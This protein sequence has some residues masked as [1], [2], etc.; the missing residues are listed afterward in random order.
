MCLTVWDTH[1]RWFTPSGSTSVWDAPNTPSYIYRFLLLA[2]LYVPTDE[3]V[4]FFI[5][6]EVFF[7]L[8]VVKT[9]IIYVGDHGERW[10]YGKVHG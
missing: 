5:Y 1:R 9:E 4:P 6:F 3:R 8:P 2:M 7:L 10:G